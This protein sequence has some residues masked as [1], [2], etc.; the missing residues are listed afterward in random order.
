MRA[1]IITGLSGAGK[2]QAA[3]ALEDIGFFCIDNMPPTL[4]P[5]FAEMAAQ[6]NKY[7][8]IA[9]VTDVR[10]REFFDGLFDA[11]EDLKKIEVPCKIL[12][13]D[14]NDEIL[15]RRYCATRRK[16]PLSEEGSSS[17]AQA[18]AD[19]RRLLDPLRQAA[20]YRID[21]SF[22]TI[23]QLKE[24]IISRFSGDAKGSMLVRCLSFGFKYGVPTEADL[25]LDVRHL[26]NP[27][28]VEEL[29]QQNGLDES[30]RAYV[31]RD[32]R[33]EELCLRYGSLLEYLL[34]QYRQEG[35]SQ[36]VIGVGCTGGK[37]RSVAVAEALCAKIGELG[38]NCKTIHRDMNK[39]L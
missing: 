8:D 5:R 9:I 17:L 2:T 3:N 15:E 13:L 34:P 31:W 25:L 7:S 16:H 30:V 4:I 38:F 33:A 6:L 26:P 32:G 36:L 11:L 20:D 37:H 21:T 35:K 19:E 27:F 1:L 22:L 28:Y 12:F 23:A 24:Q 18:I 14:A 39:L 29:K 10:G